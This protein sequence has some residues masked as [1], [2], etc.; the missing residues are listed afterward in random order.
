M[1][2]GVW[3]TLDAVRNRKGRLGARGGPL[4]VKPVWRCLR[5]N[6]CAAMRLGIMGEL[7]A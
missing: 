4:N 5:G 3:S 2:M 7:C 6:A 1:Y